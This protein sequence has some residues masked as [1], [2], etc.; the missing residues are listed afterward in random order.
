MSASG[1]NCLFDFANITT[2]CTGAVVEH[3]AFPVVDDG[4]AVAG[5]SALR[6]DEASASLPDR[7][8]DDRVEFPAQH[9][10]GVFVRAAMHDF[11]FLRCSRTTGSRSLLVE[12]A[13]VHV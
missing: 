2:P 3:A 12:R 1:D 7:Q 10:C 13:P 8:A 4:D 5:T 6:V 11:T 9:V